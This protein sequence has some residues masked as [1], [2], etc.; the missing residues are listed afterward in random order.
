MLQMLQKRK[1]STTGKLGYKDHT[2]PLFKQLRMSRIK[3]VYTLEYLKLFLWSDAFTWFYCYPNLI[4]ESQYQ[5]QYYKEL[6]RTEIQK[7]FIETN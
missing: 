3:Y 5:Y 6:S 7:R 2:V 4:S 1:V